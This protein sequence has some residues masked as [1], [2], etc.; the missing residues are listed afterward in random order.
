MLRGT[1]VIHNED[2]SVLEIVVEQS[3]TD[4][5]DERSSEEL[6]HRREGSEPVAAATNPDDLGIPVNVPDDELWKTA[7][8]PQDI[9]ARPA[10]SPDAAMPALSR[11]AL[12]PSSR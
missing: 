3:V 9:V 5:I 10:T 6:P 4:A 12:A 8:G 2:E 7:D 11:A 1:H